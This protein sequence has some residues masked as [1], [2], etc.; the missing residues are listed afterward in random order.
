[1]KEVA[2][3][4]LSGIL[5]FLMYNSRVTGTYTASPTGVPEDTGAIVSPEIVGA[6]AEQFHNE[7]K[8]LYPIETLFIDPKGDNV[9]DSRF[10][11]FNTSKFYGAQYDI[12]A[13]INSDGS[14]TI[15]K[16]TET[17]VP[18]SGGG[19]VP[20]KYR[21]WSSIQGTLDAQLKKEL[22]MPL[23]ILNANSIGKRE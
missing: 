12:Q 23:P 10:M 4:I 8:D 3:V 1:M 19:F 7:N 14:A 15:L 18:V 9:F 16:K 2:I 13:R 5:I 22:S 20:D 6:I 21:P 17:A 11:F